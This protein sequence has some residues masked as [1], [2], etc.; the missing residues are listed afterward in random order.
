VRLDLAHRELLAA[1]PEDELTV[2]EVG[3]RWG[4][5]SPSRFAERHR[6]TFGESPS[7]TLRR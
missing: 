7:E 2:T 6:E 5:C 1:S 4:F 3:Y